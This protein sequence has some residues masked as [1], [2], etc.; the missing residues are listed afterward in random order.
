M[1]GRPGNRSLFGGG[2]NV[3]CKLDRRSTVRSAAPRKPNGVQRIRAVRVS[4]SLAGLGRQCAGGPMW[5]A[6][7]ILA[8]VFFCVYF[9]AVHSVIHSRKF[10]YQNTVF[11]GFS[12][13]WPSSGK[14][15]SFDGTFWIWSDGEQLHPLADRYAEILLAVDHQRRGLEVLA[16]SST[17]RDFRYNSGFARGYP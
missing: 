16:R 15:T 7:H 5:A 17:G 3:S 1:K 9:F 4:P 13:Q 12:T 11:C 10:L 2:V 8:S 6:R 14:R